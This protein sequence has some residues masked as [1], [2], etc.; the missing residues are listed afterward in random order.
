MS[1]NRFLPAKTVKK[2]TYYALESEKIG[3]LSSQSL[4]NAALMGFLS[5][6]LNIHLPLVRAGRTMCG[7]LT[8]RVS[9]LQVMQLV[10]SPAALL[11][12]PIVA[13][14][15]R[16]IDSVGAYSETLTM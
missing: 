16:G 9:L 14:Y 12:D 2:T 4:I 13:K 8:S 5:M 3:Q 7:A 15:L 11:T 10:M 1:S 6:Q